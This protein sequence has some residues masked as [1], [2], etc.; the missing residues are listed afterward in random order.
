MIDN[1]SF[2]SGMGKMNALG[3]AALGKFLGKL[4]TM[5]GLLVCMSL[6][7][8]LN[9]AS[10]VMWELAGTSMDDAMINGVIW[11]WPFSST[12]STLNILMVVGLKESEKNCMSLS[13]IH[14]WYTGMGSYVI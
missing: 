14:N 10:G 3:A 2:S 13:C 5:V 12:G 1:V 8:L 9:R 11:S 4:W 6:N 7:D